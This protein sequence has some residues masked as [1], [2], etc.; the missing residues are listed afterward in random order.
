MDLVIVGPGRAGMS[1]ALAAVDAGHRIAAVMARRPDAARSAARRLGADVLALDDPVPSCDLVV[2]AVRDD[3]IPSVAERLAPLPP[4]APRVVH[5]SGLTPVAALDPLRPASVGSLHPLQTLPDPEVGSARLAGAWVA[6]TSD[7]DELADRLF[8][9]ARSVGMHPFELADGDKAL[10]HAAAAAAANYPLAALSMARRL[11]EAAGVPFEAAGPLVRAVVDNAFALGPDEA[12]TGPIA[13]GDVGTVAAQL[14]AVAKADPSL[15]PHF[16]SMA[17]ATAA[18][19]GT[20]AVF[21][22][23][24][25]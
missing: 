25:G 14:A 1:L 10:Y 5:V 2:L 12:L 22:E 4:H 18:V 6:V 3:A 8:A 19:A 20:G 24:L 15:A 11:F 16:A 23:V 7:D 17:R 21:E 13:R 9:L